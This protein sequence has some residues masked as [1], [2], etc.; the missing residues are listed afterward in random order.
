LNLKEKPDDCSRRV[1]G[2]TMNGTSNVPSIVFGH[3]FVK[4]HTSQ[5]QAKTHRTQSFSTV[6][7]RPDVLRHM[8]RSCNITFDLLR[9]SIDSGGL[10]SASLNDI[11]QLSHLSKATIWHALHRL[12][13]VHLIRLITKG[14]RHSK[15]VFQVL[16]CSPLATYQQA[17]VH[18]AITST[19]EKESYSHKGRSVL[20]SPSKK[21]LGW[22]M[23]RIR[24]EL[25]DY[26]ITAKRK[27][28]ILTGLGASLWHSMKS[29]TVKAGKQLANVVQGLIQRLRDAQG[30]GNNLRSWCSCAGWMLR[31]ELTEQRE[32]LQRLEESRRQLAQ[33][34]REKA[35]AAASWQAAGFSH[36]QQLL[37]KDASNN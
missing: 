31:G 25:A 5:T 24:D 32:R 33:I 18:L 16:W 28:L 15:A 17:S 8:P 30:I 29:G 34:R 3:A 11:A 13:G 27:R 7:H 21:A 35:E 9:F 6:A 2:H 22:A 37:P 12:A 36:W 23:S 14:R 26:G 4:L 1:P 10:V 19:P 20:A